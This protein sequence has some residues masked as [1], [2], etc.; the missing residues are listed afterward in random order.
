MMFHE[1]SNLHLLGI[2]RIRT[3]QIVMRSDLVVGK[4]LNSLKV[5]KPLNIGLL[6]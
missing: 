2:E 1:G 5:L 3:S 4:L 6:A